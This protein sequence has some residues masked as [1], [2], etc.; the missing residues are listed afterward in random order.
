MEIWMIENNFPASIFRW[1]IQMDGTRDEGFSDIEKY[2][3]NK[4][5]TNLDVY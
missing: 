2:L 5:Q 4:H 3:I 1:Q